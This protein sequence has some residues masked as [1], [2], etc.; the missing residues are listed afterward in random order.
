MIKSDIL[1]VGDGCMDAYTYCNTNRLAPEAPCPVLDV[2]HVHKAPGMAMNVYENVNSFTTS[3]EFVTNENWADI[4]KNRYVHTKTN[5]HFCRIDSGVI[6]ET[7][8]REELDLDRFQTVII[9]DYDKGFLTPDDIEYICTNHP[10]VFLDTKKVLDTWSF[11]AKFIKINEYEYERSK[12]Y[13]DTLGKGQVI[14]T[15]G[16]Q[17]CE[18]NGKIYPVDKVEVLDV[19]GAG[20]TFM[21]ALAHKYTRMNDIIKAINFAN[22]CASQVVQMRGTSVL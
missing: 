1:V 4:I 22:Y 5:H 8:N 3:A 10:Q 13:V 20:D 18:F 6:E 19:S 11:N 2:S 16:G 12:S 21:A 15:L 14:K 7:V 17:G 9:S